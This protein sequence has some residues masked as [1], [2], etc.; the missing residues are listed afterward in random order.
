MLKWE[1]THNLI[2]KDSMEPLHFVAPANPSLHD[3]FPLLLSICMSANLLN[4]VHDMLKKKIKC[5]INDWKQ[6][7]NR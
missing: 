6:I 7:L 2:H 1:A 4:I 5:L 3:S